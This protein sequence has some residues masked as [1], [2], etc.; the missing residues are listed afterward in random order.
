MTV[1]NIHGLYL[2][3]DALANGNTYQT[4]NHNGHLRA[5]PTNILEFIQFDK[6]HYSTISYKPENLHYHYLNGNNLMALILVKQIM[7]GNCISG[8]KSGASI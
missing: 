6:Q 4:T 5:K 2:T 8:E 3:S 7:T 1:E